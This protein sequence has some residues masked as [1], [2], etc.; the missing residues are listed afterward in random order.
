[1][2]RHILVPTDG[3]KLAGKAVAEAVKLASALGSRLTFLTVL[4]PL[5]TLG[6]YE[7]AFSGAPEKVRHAAIEFLEADSKTALN[8]ALSIAKSAGLAADTAWV[9]GHYPHEA[10]IEAAKSNGADLIVMASHGRSGSKAVLLGSV[11]QKVL[12]HTQL[13]VLVVR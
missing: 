8:A 9:E 12:S 5:N 6:D 7:H 11:T 1:M 4:V 2:Y 3:S 10:I 13:P